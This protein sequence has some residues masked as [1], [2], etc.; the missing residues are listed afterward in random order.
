MNSDSY[1]VMLAEKSLPE[2]IFITGSDYLFQQ[3]NVSFHVSRAPR[4][5]FETNCVQNL[6]C[7]PSDLNLTEDL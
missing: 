2:A 5:W 3:D 7:Q 1:A 4:S 6:N